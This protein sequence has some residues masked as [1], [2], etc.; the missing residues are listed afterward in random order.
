MAANHGQEQWY[1]KENG[2]KGDE[3]VGIASTASS[4]FIAEEVLRDNAEMI[5]RLWNEQA[6]DTKE[7]NTSTNSKST[8]AKMPTLEECQKEVQ[9]R[10][11]AGGFVGTSTNITETVYNF[12]C[13]HI[14]CA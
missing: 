3:L 7:Q 12:I 4:W 5:C 11:W 2:G 1:I 8:Q 6:A 9:S 13:R 10:I 14:G